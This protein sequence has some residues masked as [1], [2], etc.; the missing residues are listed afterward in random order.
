MIKKVLIF[1]YTQWNQVVCSLIEGLKLNKNLEL[2][3]TTETNY[4]KDISIK[5]K[6]RYFPFATTSD[7]IHEFDDAGNMIDGPP[8][9]MNV[10]S[11]VV[12]EDSY[13]DECKK[14]MDKCDLIIIFDEGHEMSSAHYYIMDEKNKGIPVVT[15][16]E[17]QNTV[18]YSL[19]EYAVDNY[20]DKIVM[21]DPT[22]WGPQGEAKPDPQITHENFD[23]AAL[24]SQPLEYGMYGRYKGGHP[25][26]CKVYFKREKSLDLKW[27]D[28][29][30]P[31]PFASEERYFTIEKNFEKIWSNK[32]VDISCLFRVKA[33]TEGEDLVRGHIRRTVKYHCDIMGN[34]KHIIGAVYDDLS[35]DPIEEI[36]RQINGMD[37]SSYKFKYDKI[38]GRPRRHHSTYYNTLLKT[39]INIEGLPGQH[40]F[41]TGRMMESLANGCCYFYPKPNYRPDFPNGLID[42]EDFI[43]YNTPE[44]LV[45]RLHY[46]L[47]HPN[48]MK[49]IA[50]NGFNKL[51]KYHTSEVRAKE[52]IETCERYMSEN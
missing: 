39:K 21:I 41:Y 31:M 48:E 15:N 44:D 35:V 42:G 13:N 5:T 49:I 18:V 6:Q 3:S 22:D 20:K 11:T 1:N 37:I 12:D 2:Y 45:E 50:E 16:V 47:S 7:G 14:L 26:D 10:H 8:P 43:I 33:Y 40:A 28:N 29:V 19:H 27:E 17:R 51:L 38:L 4:A 25:N 52:F 32:D 46:Y 34:I 9:D 30:E 36:E 24:S 23:V